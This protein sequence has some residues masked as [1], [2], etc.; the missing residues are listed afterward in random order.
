MDEPQANTNSQNS[1]WPKLEGSHHLPPYSILCAWPRDQHPNVILFWDSQVGVS[2]FPKLGLSR[3]WGPIILC[4][5]LRLRWG[6]NQS[7]NPHKKKFNNM[8]HA[9]YTQ[10]NRGDSQLLVV[11]GQIANLTPNPFFGHNLCFKCPNGSCKLILNIY[12][13]RDFQWYKELFNPMGFDPWNFSLKIWEFIGTPTPKVGAHLGVWGF[14]PSHSPTL[15]GTWDV[16][17]RLPFW[18]TTLQALA[19]VVSP[20]LGLQQWHLYVELLW[21]YLCHWGIHVCTWEPMS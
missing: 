15:M 13:T 18:P 21:H 5:N 14:I 9:T 6:L 7:C 1:P 4:E 12:G 10:G 3:L 19:L 16:T 11:E 2:K 17:P 20:R 8:W